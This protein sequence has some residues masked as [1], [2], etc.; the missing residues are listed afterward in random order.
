MAQAAIPSY[1]GNPFEQATPGL[2][3]GLLLP[4]WTADWRKDDTG[5]REAWRK[6]Q[7][8]TDADRARI[9]ALGKRQQAMAEQRHGDARF[10]IIAQAIAPFTTGLGNEHPLENGFSF[11]SPYGLPYLPGSGVKGVLRTAARELQDGLFGST[12][13]W[14]Q[15]FTV[16]NTPRAVVD[17]LFGNDPE[18]DTALRGALSFWDVVPQFKG[19]LAVEIMTPHQ[20]HYY[21]DGQ[22]PHDS[23]QPN[24][25]LFLAIPPG[26]G[27]TF[28]VA[29][30]LARLPDELK[31]DNRWQ[32][33]L[34]TAFE[35]AFDWLGFGAKTA[36]GYGAM[37]EDPAERKSKELAAQAR[38]AAAQQRAE[39]ERAQQAAAQRDAEAQAH[40]TAFAALPEAEQWLQTA[41]IALARFAN[42][43]PNPH[44]SLRDEVNS[45]IKPLREQA[46]SWADAGLRERAADALHRAFDAIGWHDPGAKSDKKKKQREKRASQIS[47]IRKGTGS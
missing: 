25:I 41:D 2:R 36:V 29:C 19:D 40:A 34:Q 43:Q 8:L 23:G 24:P 45:A 38:Q 20:G 4:V 7:K 31:A 28:H 17:I 18:D 6:I 12:C 39:A 9:A 21:Q 46:A 42:A 26:A 1:L 16:G 14:D 37:R 5:A 32:T 3:F 27:F 35:H 22:A 10:C 30:D 33:L 47:N 44:P 15:T 11:L 13:G